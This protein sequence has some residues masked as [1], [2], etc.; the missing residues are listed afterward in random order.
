MY[1]DGIFD[2]FDLIKNAFKKKPEAPA[3]K[4]KRGKKV[5]KTNKELATERGEPY[6]DVVKVEFDSDSPRLGSF[7]ID[8]NQH[9][10][11]MLVK[12][13][14]V[15]KSPEQI[16]DQWFTD[17]CRNVVL[18]TYEQEQADPSARVIKKDLG[19]GRTEIG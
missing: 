12:H 6:V 9:F 2:M 1:M 15:G 3:P 4:V 14:Y 18:E 13:G 16:V 11:E 8:W 19:N 17:L 5:E 10:V 7:E